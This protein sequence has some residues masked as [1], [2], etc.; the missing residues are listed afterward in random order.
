MYPHFHYEHNQICSMCAAV[1]H[2]FFIYLQYFIIVVFFYFI[3]LANK[4]QV[5]DQLKLALAWN[6][7]DIAKSEIFVDDRSWEVVP[8]HINIFIYLSGS[9]FVYV[10]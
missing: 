5:Y 9:R 3:I 6:R 1:K 7:I 10:Y 4:D 8:Y 2:V